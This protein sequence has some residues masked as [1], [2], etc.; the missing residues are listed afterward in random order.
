[1]INFQKKTVK[2]AEIEPLCAKY[3]INQ[4]LA[5]I[6]VR[7]GITSGTDLMY[8]LEDDSR[9]L[10]NS[11]CFADI[12]DAVERIIQAK[13]DKEK[14][15]VFGDSDVDGIT[16]TAIL[17][18]YLEKFGCNVQWRLPLADDAYGLSIAAVD[19]FANEGG[20]LIIT[21]DCGIS[22][23]E[24]TKHAAK[25]GIDV[26]ITDH[27]NPQKEIPP[28]LVILN[29]KIQELNYPFS[30]ISGAAVSYK[31]VSALRFA[32]SDFY[33][34]E[35]CL[36]DIFED[37]ENNCFKIDCLKV[38]NLTKIKEL[39][40]TI[41]PGKTSVYDLKLPYFLQGQV[42]FVWDEQ[43]IQKI[44]HNV[45]GSSVEFNLQDLKKEISKIS[46][47]LGK[48]TIEQLNEVSVFAK[49]SENAQK[50]SINTLFNLY[51]TYSKKINSQKNPETEED[52]RKDLQ[53]VALA[54]LA[55]IMPMKNEN[56]IL[57]KCG[58]NS[59]KKDGPRPGLA[60]LFNRLKIST[61]EINSA[62]LSWNVIPA[63]NA[64]GRLGK[65]DLSLKLLISK[66]SKEREQLAN[67]VFDLNEERKNLVSQA[68]FK[69]HDEAE[70]NL[71]ENNDK[72]CICVDDCINK[73]VTGLVAN[74]LMQDFNTPAM[75]IS[76]CNDFCVGS[77]RTCRGFIATD[78]L[79]KFGNFFKNYGGHD[80]AAGF[81]FQKEKLNLFLEKAKNFTDEIILTDDKSKNISI[82]A[83][84]P[85]SFLTPEL[86][87]ILDI[88]EPFGNENSELIFYTQKIK[89]CDVQIVGKK[90]P[91]HLKL[92]FDTVKHKITGMYWGQSERFGKD[93]CVGQSYDILYNMGKNYFNGLTTNQIIIKDLQPAN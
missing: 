61:D 34:A 67:T 41:I 14:I 45:F 59:M 10:H 13:E 9:F 62:T 19:D 28:A 20:S 31:L 80:F 6:F 78:F 51:V 76:F 53:L 75:V 54:A 16:S 93:I 82:D 52:D 49:Y 88:F 84:V 32:Q 17:Y 21:V 57:V 26:I 35:I 50:N 47:A 77:I 83:Q 24:E 42:I 2:K 66:D 33:N 1:M 5:S 46:P 81:S 38:R 3:N 92:T 58:I 56:R 7:R 73:G 91:A 15:L 71:H 48:K 65:S 69:I 68:I 89:L 4:I 79:E 55:D 64:A 74:K 18:N 30:D 43:K 8:F 39:H 90:E 37:K 12:E 27:H 87:E 29:P 85:V 25:L 23:V 72:L 40:E 86:F 36:F 44:L 63:L 22:N 11:F 60:E 70:K